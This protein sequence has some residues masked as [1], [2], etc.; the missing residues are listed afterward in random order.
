MSKLTIIIEIDHLEDVAA[1]NA[2]NSFPF[3]MA[4]Q[5]MRDGLLVDR[6][7]SPSMASL[8]YYMVIAFINRHKAAL[9]R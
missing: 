7:Q 9:S 1:I 2:N 8:V 4:A 6:V 5:L 3:K